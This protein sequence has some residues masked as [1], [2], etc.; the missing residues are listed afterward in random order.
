VPSLKDKTGVNIILGI[1][2]IPGGIMEDADSSDF[3][4]LLAS[5]SIIFTK[6]PDD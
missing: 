2:G 6:V 3:T 5:I 1:W 4:T